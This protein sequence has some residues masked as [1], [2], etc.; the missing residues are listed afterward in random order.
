MSLNSLL[1][2]DFRENIPSKRKG[3]F[4]IEYK[5]IL[6]PLDGSKFAEIVLPH[7]EALTSTCNITNIEL[8]SVVP[9]LEM[10]YGA[11]VPLDHK[12]EEESNEANVKAAQAYLESV[13]QKLKSISNVTTR[14]LRGKVS[15]SLADY[16][17]SSGAD[18]LVMA[19]HGR[20]GPGRWLLGSVADRMLQISPIPIFIVRPTAGRPESPS[21]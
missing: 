14:V 4:K 1:P 9:G 17:V 16:I 7:L 21:N 10:H 12:E 11:A 18:L 20:S 2:G 8:V 5:K 19:T 6:V 13:K 15:E 3:V